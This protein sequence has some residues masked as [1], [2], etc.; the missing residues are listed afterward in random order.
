MTALCLKWTKPNC[1]I[2]LDVTV[3]VVRN[4]PKVDILVLLVIALSN[5]ELTSCRI[6]RSVLLSAAVIVVRPVLIIEVGTHWKLVKG[7]QSYL[8]LSGESRSLGQTV[9]LWM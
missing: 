1:C 5:K 8:T 3:S 9:H 4:S 7:I 2:K 6:L